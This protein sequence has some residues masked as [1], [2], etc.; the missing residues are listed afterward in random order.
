MCIIILISILYI[1]I[2]SKYS[3]NTYLYHLNLIIITC[4]LYIFHY[5]YYQQY[6]IYKNNMQFMNCCVYKFNNKKKY[7]DILIIFLIEC[8]ILY[9]I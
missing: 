8:I 4:S 3:M 7:C 1:T 5:F 9:N 6:F 2:A